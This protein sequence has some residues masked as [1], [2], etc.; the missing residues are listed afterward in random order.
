MCSI[1]QTTNKSEK[2]ADCLAKINEA[3]IHL[4]G[5][6]NSVLDLAKIETGNFNLINAELNLSQTLRKT[7]EI[8]KFTLDAKKQNLKLD[9]DPALPEF[10]VSDEQRLTQVLE[11]LLSNAVKF[12]PPEG[13]ISL[14]VK[15]LTE[16]EKTCTLRIEVADTG[17]GISTEKM[18]K[19]FALFEQLDGGL[20]RK[21]EGTG[22]GLPISTKIIQLMGGQIHVDSKPGQGSCFSFEITVQR[23][24]NISSRQNANTS[25][26]DGKAKFSGKAIILAEDVEINREIILSLFEGTDLTINCAENGLE[27]L[28]KYKADPI[29]YDLILMDIHMPEMDGYEATRHIRAFENERK[30]TP[31]PIVA[32]TANVFNEDV[33]KC[34]E[35]GMS[36]HLGKPIDCGELME[37]LDKFI[38]N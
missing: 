12:T 34:L 28:E 25:S 21:Y 32:M 11:N 3:S 20:V 19:A 17:I 23:G 37:T 26:V 18:K 36:C 22:M 14:S 1:A 6:I 13:T 10:I 4:L 7:V 15:K 35:A 24:R 30:K 2:L 33:E 8:I 16:D 29:K 27:A 31:V 5:M 38:E 9:F